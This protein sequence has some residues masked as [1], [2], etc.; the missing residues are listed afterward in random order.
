M[1]LDDCLKL[2]DNTEIRR[3]KYSEYLAYH[4]RKSKTFHVY[5]IYEIKRILGAKERVKAMRN[6]DRLMSIS[7]LDV[8]SL[9]EQLNDE[10]INAGDWKIMSNNL[11]V[12]K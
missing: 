4:K 11:E 1:N 5:F 10:D 6:E 12:I 2:D 9:A 8:Y 7:E 3:K